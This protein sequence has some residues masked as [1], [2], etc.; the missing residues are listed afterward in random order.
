[1][2]VWPSQSVQCTWFVNAAENIKAH[3]LYES[4]FGLE[5]D[6]MQQS[7]TVGP[8]NPFFSHS[9]G[10]LDGM[11][12]AVQVQ[13]GRVDAILAPDQRDDSITMDTERAIKLLTAKLVEMP[14][15]EQSVF[16]VAFVVN[17]FSDFESEEAAEKELFSL[18]GITQEIPNAKSTMFQVNSPFD[19]TNGAKINRLVRYSSLAVQKFIL[20]IP[21]PGLEA[22]AVPASVAVFGVQLMLDFNTV[23]DGTVISNELQP[24]L[25]AD[26]VSEVLRVSN[27]RSIGALSVVR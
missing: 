2:S 12:A 5:P 20:N 25:F 8:A 22:A 26:L 9:T 23:P 1:M 7:K 17:L 10:R 16:R 21:A 4:L 24:K 11:T 14:L 27:D 6:T 15:I 18:A 3:T 19:G 13:P